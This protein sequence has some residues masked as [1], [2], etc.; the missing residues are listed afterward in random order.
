MGKKKVIILICAIVAVA[1]AAAGLLYYFVFREKSP[2]SDQVVYVDSVASIAGLS[3]GN[4]LQNRYS[5]VVE[6]QETSEIKKNSEKTIKEL[7]V[8]VGDNV[9]V[10]TQLFSY[11]TDELALNLEQAKID[12]ESL[13]NEIAN[14][15]EQIKQLEKEKAAAS[16]SEKLG[17]TTQIQSAQMSA[18]RAEYN[19]QSKEVEIANL[20]KSIENSVVVSELDGVVKSISEGGY[21]SLT[22][23]E[24]PYMTIVAVGNYK[25]KGKVAEQNVQ[26]F[27]PGQSVVIRSRI[28]ET[29]TWN[30]TITEIDLE[31]TESNTNNGYYMSSSSDSGERST[32][33]PFYIELEDSAD[34]M[35]GQHVFIELDMG[36]SEVKEGL[37]L[38]AMY[39]VIEGNDAYVWASNKKDRLEKRK[40]TLGDYD[41]E[42]DEYQVLDG[43]TGEDYIA[44]PT[45]ELEEGMTCVINDGSMYMNGMDDGTIDYND[46]MDDGMIDY[47]DDMEGG[48]DDGIQVIPEGDAGDG[49]QQSDGGEVTTLPESNE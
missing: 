5:G 35:L 4:G 10:G 46:G 41:S 34:L 21:D 33:Y 8:K 1:A 20:Q 40:I 30:G 42:L 25:V 2:S 16:A 23:Q 17:Y 19:K 26:Y 13:N 31:N 38:N 11:D 6:S 15:A 29:R 18:K 12:L 44:W 48:V 37:W 24:L 3:S 22:G 43:L 7:F 49:M 39:M 14:Y 27:M 47:N 45:E 9:T 32:S 28:D 36:Q